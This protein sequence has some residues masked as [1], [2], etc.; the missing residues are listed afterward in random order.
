MPVKGEIGRIQ[1]RGG[2]EI[3][4]KNNEFWGTVTRLYLVKGW[5][6]YYKMSCFPDVNNIII[7]TQGHEI[8]PQSPWTW[9]TFLN[10]VFV[11]CNFC[12]FM[13]RRYKVRVEFW[14]NIKKWLTL[15]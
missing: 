12:V 10:I 14:R 6:Q 7:M 4:I 13:Q 15:T 9:S 11:W 5:L 2:W 3:S 8:M 1:I